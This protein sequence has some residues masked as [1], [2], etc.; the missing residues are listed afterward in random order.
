M[1]RDATVEDGSDVFRNVP[2][3][4]KTRVPPYSL[5]ASPSGDKK[6]AIQIQHSGSRP[7]IDSVGF[8]FRF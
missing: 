5:A 2:P 4:D 8:S 6:K 7:T 1:L 3:T